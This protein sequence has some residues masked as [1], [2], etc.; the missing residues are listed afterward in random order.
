LDMSSRPIWTL[1]LCLFRRD[2]LPLCTLIFFLFACDFIADLDLIAWPV[3]TL[4]RFL[5]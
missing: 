5:F 3:W 1:I 4:I 2:L